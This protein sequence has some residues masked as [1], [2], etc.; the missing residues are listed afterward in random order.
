VESIRLMLE[1]LPL[2][3]LNLVR[4]ARSNDWIAVHARL[5]NHADQTDDVAAVLMAQVDADLISASSRLDEDLQKARKR[6]ANTLV[7]AAMLSLAAA[8]LLGAMVTR[9]ITQPLS[10]LKAGARALAKGEFGYRVPVTGNDELAHLALA[11]NSSAAELARLFEESRSERANAESAHAA[12]QEHVRELARVNVDL[13]QF[14][15]SASH[16]LQEPMRTVALYCQLLQRTYAGRLDERADEYI[17]YIVRSAL[18]M[19]RLLGDLLAYTRTSAL[20]KPV[21]EVAD[22]NAILCR[23]LSILEPQIT[24]E[25]CALHAEQLPKVAAH[26]IH[27]QQLLQNLLGNALKYRSDRDPEIHIS[28]TPQ[29]DRWLFAIRDNGIG[30]SPVYAKQIFGIFKRLHGQKYEGTGMGLAICQRIVQL[31]GGE[32]WVDSEL[33]QGATFC[34]TLPAA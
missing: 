4:L 24:S 30:I 19:S 23:V 29:Q 27:V 8:A 12:L 15:Y 13:Q 26:E 22:A 28:V 16:D 1:R 5:L 3:I 6:A 10:L 11:F 20:G 2:R 9:S 33:G 21:G 17:G 34:F 32:I 7:L 18:Q 14:A 31:Y 25:R